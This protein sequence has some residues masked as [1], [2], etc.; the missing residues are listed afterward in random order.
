[1]ARIAGCT[2]VI[3]SARRS[4]ENVSWAYYN[5]GLAYFAKD[6]YEPEELQGIRFLFLEKPGAAI[7]YHVGEGITG[8]VVET[9]RPVVVPRELA[10]CCAG[11]RL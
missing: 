2:A 3:R 9:G 4:G 5:R 7:Q 6:Q 11:P 10:P 1:M 8:K